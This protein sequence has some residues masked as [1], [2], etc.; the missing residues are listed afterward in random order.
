VVAG[1][2]TVL[3]DSRRA[4]ESFEFHLDLIV[5][6]FYLLRDKFGIVLQHTSMRNAAMHFAICGFR[7][8]IAH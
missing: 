2:G 5:L 4:Q 1:E 6:F 3:I 8:V 7:E